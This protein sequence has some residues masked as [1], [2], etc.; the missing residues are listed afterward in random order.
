MAKPYQ[1][2]KREQRRAGRTCADC[3]TA[4]E[5]L[6]ALRL[7][8]DECQRLLRNQRLRDWR[9]A[10][11][12]LSKAHDSKRQSQRNSERME[13]YRNDPE[14]RQRQIDKVTKRAAALGVG[15]RRLRSIRAILNRDGVLCTYCGEFLTDPFDGQ[16]THVDHIQPPAREA[17]VS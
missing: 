11:P 8:C 4:I 2:R 9:K 5:H 1:I 16:A 12:E 14:F 6:H 10:E 17:T 3:G 7:R 13:R 15:Y